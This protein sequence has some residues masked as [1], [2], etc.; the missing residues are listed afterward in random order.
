[1]TCLKNK[2]KLSIFLILPILITSCSQISS[3]Y[4]D[5]DFHI[6]VLSD[7]HISSDGQKEHLLDSLV[8]K[9]NEGS[10]PGVELLFVTGDVGSS[11]FKDFNADDPEKGDNRVRK[12]VNIFNNLKIPFHLAMGNHDHKRHS[13]RDSDIPFT[14]DEILE[15]ED[16]WRVTTGLEPNYSFIHKGWKFIIMNS[17]HGN[18]LGKNFDEEQLNWLE[19]ELQE[20]N[21]L[22]LF[23]H[24]PIETDNFRIW[25][26]FHQVMDSDQEPIF[27][28]LLEGNKNRIKG[29]FVGHGHKWVHDKLF[30]SIEVYETSSMA[31]DEALSYYVVGIDT[32]ANLISVGKTATPERIK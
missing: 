27:Y 23:F 29:I 19:K 5:G 4:P 20:R 7:I 10:Y 32:L 14:K 21:P 3:A 6:M 30:D 25:G 26:K 1:M 18:Y 9:I 8:E 11:F 31:D 16:F 12:A 15:M 28:E 24:H 17:M 13:D 2:K 22:M